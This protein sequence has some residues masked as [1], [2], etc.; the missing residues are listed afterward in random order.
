MARAGIL[1]PSIAYRDPLAAMD[2]LSRAFGFEIG[3]L[4]TDEKGNLAHAEMTYRGAE[5]GIMGEW[6]APMLGPNPMKSP[7]A[8]AAATGFIWV[9]VE[10]LK[11]HCEA[12]RAAGAHIVQEPV[13]QPYGD[14]TYRA[15][16]CEGH[17]WCFREHV[18]DVSDAAFE[19]QTGLKYRKSL[20]EVSRS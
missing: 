6:G 13:E 16:D 9:S 11:A 14:A 19:A 17:V 3:I 5:I 7:A 18:K 20:D 15:L 4:L 1:V 10:K 2:F 12:A 8:L